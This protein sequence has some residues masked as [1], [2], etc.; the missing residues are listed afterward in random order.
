MYVFYESCFSLWNSTHTHTEKLQNNTSP[1]KDL[2]ADKKKKEPWNTSGSLQLSFRVTV[3]RRTVG[4]V[5][6]T[7]FVLFV[8]AFLVTPVASLVMCRVIQ[9]HFWKMKHLDSTVLN[10]LFKA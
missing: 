9:V 7:R 6:R 10:Y 8:V 5:Q 4:R 2:Y 1:T 3:Y